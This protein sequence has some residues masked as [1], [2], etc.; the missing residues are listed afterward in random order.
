[1]T[2]QLAVWGIPIFLGL[3]LGYIFSLPVNIII[4]LIALGV[5]L[6][7]LYATR[8]DEI[9]SLVGFIAI[10][11]AGIFVVAQWVTIIL[12]TGFFTNWHIAFSW[13]FR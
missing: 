5:G 2:E 12:I 11:E 1:M 8:N 4:S 10:V 7:L 9:G 6:Y 13:L 3:V